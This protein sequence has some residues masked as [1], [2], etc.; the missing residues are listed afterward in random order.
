MY[1]TTSRAVLQVSP[2]T[3]STHTSK[4]SGARPQPRT[5]HQTPNARSSAATTARTQRT[6]RAPCWK[7]ITAAYKARPPSSGST[8]SRFT[9]VST[10]LIS[11]ASGNSP[12]RPSQSSAPPAGPESAQTIPRQPSCGAAQCSTGP[13]AVRE[14]ASTLH[15]SRRSAS[16]CPSSCADTAQSSPSAAVPSSRNASSPTSSAP[17]G[18]TQKPRSGGEI[19]LRIQIDPLVDQLKMQMRPRGKPRRADAGDALP[20]LDR[21]PG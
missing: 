15:E 10:K 6:I 7:C 9:A 2:G 19:E 18:V 8:G 5:A 4:S 21:I 14:T 17:P 20:R 12:R 13:V 11:A 16:T 1:F 3:R